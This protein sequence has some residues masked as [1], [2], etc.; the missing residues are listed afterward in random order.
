MANAGHSLD[1][2]RRERRRPA[3]GREACGSCAPRQ[4]R[5]DE[6]QLPPIQPRPA[7]CPGALPSARR[8]LLLAMPGASGVRFDGSRRGC[9]PPWPGR[10]PGQSTAQL[11]ADELP[12]RR[13]RGVA[14]TH[15][16]RG[17]RCPTIPPASSQHW[18]QVTA[19]RPVKLVAMF[20]MHV[21]RASIGPVPTFDLGGPDDIIR[22]RSR[23]PLATRRPMVS[24]SQHR[25]TKPRPPAGTRR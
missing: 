20:A 23:L 3:L 21:D 6:L 8:A 18:R 17:P 5:D 15:Q 24:A 13:S 19:G 12:C 7:A 25:R 2:D 9:G 16:G 11:P 14:P 22:P 4:L 1:E 10:N